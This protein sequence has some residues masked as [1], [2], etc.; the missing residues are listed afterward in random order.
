MYFRNSGSARTTVRIEF[1]NDHPPV[2]SATIVSFMFKEDGTG[3]NF[4]PD[5]ELSDSDERCNTS[6]L[7]ELQFQVHNYDVGHEIMAVD[8]VS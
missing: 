1:I 8:E 2:V 3:V 4:A 6:I 7:K 5:I